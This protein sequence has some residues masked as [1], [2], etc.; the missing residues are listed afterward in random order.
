MFQN[1][2]AMLPRILAIDTPSWIKDFVVKL[3]RIPVHEMYTFLVGAP[4][5]YL[6][7]L[8]QFSFQ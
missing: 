1:M 3:A 5:N 6:F 7:G 8:M 2:P 4:Y